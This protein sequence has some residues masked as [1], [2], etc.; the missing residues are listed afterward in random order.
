MCDECNERSKFIPKIV[1]RTNLSMEESRWSELMNNDDLDLT[2]SETA[3]GWHFCP[4]W[5][6]LLIGPGM[7]EFEHCCPCGVGGNLDV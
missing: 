1:E 7:W 3:H 2:D 4:E 6:G 5:D